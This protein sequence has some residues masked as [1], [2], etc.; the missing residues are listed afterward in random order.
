MSYCHSTL[1]R[2][3][4][5]RCVAEL[6]TASLIQ[7]TYYTPLAQ[8]IIY[9]TF[10]IRVKGNLQLFYDIYWLAHSL[11]GIQPRAW[12]DRFI[13]NNRR[14]SLTLSIILCIFGYG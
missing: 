11:V 9:E 7:S 10:G 12:R 4:C 5:E 3:A 13:L 2:P 1:L 6:K 8:P 14:K